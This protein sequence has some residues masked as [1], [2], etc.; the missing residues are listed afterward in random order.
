MLTCQGLFSH[1]RATYW[2]VPVLRLSFLASMTVEYAG[3]KSA[4]RKSHRLKSKEQ[5]NQLHSRC[6][7]VGKSIRIL[8]LR[9]T[10]M[11]Q[12][13]AE[14]TD[15]DYVVISMS[16]QEVRQLDSLPAIT[17]LIILSFEISRPSASCRRPWKQLATQERQ[18]VVTLKRAS[19]WFEYAHVKVRNAAK[20]WFE[21]DL[22]QVCGQLYPD[23]ARDH[24]DL[25][26][27]LRP[28]SSSRA[29]EGIMAPGDRFGDPKLI[30]NGIQSEI[31]ADDENVAFAAARA[32]RS[33]DGGSINDHS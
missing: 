14:S 3:L 23:S 21:S 24:R 27:S 11:L 22:G 8:L 5:S 17:L 6:H 28:L 29:R 31:L 12:A 26:L 33:P 20:L 10:T 25:T 30:Q 7:R 2:H 9:S 32:L 18:L 16:W 4:E 19:W 15:Y 13:F 1:E